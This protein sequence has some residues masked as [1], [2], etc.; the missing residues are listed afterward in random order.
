MDSD[1]PEVSRALIEQADACMASGAYGMAE[2]WLL[3]HLK[4][5]PEDEGKG[6]CLYK[7]YEVKRLGGSQITDIMLVAMAAIDE[8]PS[9]SRA[10][11]TLISLAHMLEDL[12][13]Y[14][15]AQIQYSKIGLLRMTSIGRNRT[16]ADVMGQA[17]LGSA[18]CLLKMGEIVKA[19]HILREICNNYGSGA[20]R[21]EA[22]Y[23]WAT[24]ARENGQLREAARRLALA[25]LGQ[26]DPELQARILFEKFVEGKGTP[27]QLVELTGRLTNLDTEADIAFARK[28]YIYCFKELA[29]DRDFEGMQ[30]VLDM[31]IEQP[32]AD[33][34]P[35]FTFCLEV[36]SVILE[37]EGLDAF[38]QFLESYHSLFENAPEAV[39]ASIEQMIK[40][41]EYID[42][43]TR[44]VGKLL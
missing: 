3:M 27:K 40:N 37:N 38:S 6:D 15:L 43:T 4:R 1:Q 30:K 13:L 41:V 14:N 2:K 33:Q 11:Q 16:E 9:D 10:L 36:A 5:F 44:I 22:A 35:L 7:L 18:R 25:E 24:I 26:V 39:K 42:D 31:A 12:G 20:V 29:T 32:F 17:V 28:A 23:L 21:S 8:N 34:L 19:D